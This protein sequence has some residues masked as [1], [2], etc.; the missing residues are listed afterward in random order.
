LVPL[1][2]HHISWWGGVVAQQVLNKVIAHSPE[3][4]LGHVTK[5]MSLT[6]KDNKIESLVC[7]D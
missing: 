4:V 2:F 1:N 5:T 3:K 6:W 7:F